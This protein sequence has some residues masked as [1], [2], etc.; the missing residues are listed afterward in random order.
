MNL[1]TITLLII[2]LGVHMAEIRA[3]QTDYSP[4]MWTVIENRWRES[5]PVIVVYTRSGEVEAGQ[6]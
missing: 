5:Q 2:I 1:K 3:Q 6:G 4:E